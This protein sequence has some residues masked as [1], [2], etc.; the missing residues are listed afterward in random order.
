[1]HTLA[2]LAEAVGA[3][4]VGDGATEIRGVQPFELAGPGDI[5]L[6]GDRGY[7]AKLG[8]CRAAAAIV[9][10]RVNAEMP[11]LVVRN[12]KL[13]FARVLNLVLERPY[14]PTG[15]SEQAWI[16]PECGIDESASIHGFAS[17]GART[18][19]GARAIVHSA[20]VVGEGCRIGADSVLHP[21]VVLYPGVTLGERVVLHGGTVIGADGF[22][23]V[24]DGQQQVKLPQTGTVEIQDDV[25]IGANSCVDRATF[26]KTVIEKGVKLDNHVHV[27]HNCRIGQNTVIVGCVGISGSVDVGRNCVFAGQSGVGDHVR[28]GDNVVVMAKS[29]VTRDVPADSVVSGQ[30]AH[31]HRE[32]LRN[33]A[34]IRRLPELFA[35]LR[36]TRARLADLETRLRDA[37]V[38]GS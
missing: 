11:L 4:V 6:A 9:S 1:M 26:G 33:T 28:I 35:E 20:A 19:I 21:H 34:L 25:E 7:L 8:D 29:S 15:V 30:P 14:V 16:G 13:A 32:E 37:H 38:D 23:Y 12:P 10:E 22:G 27:G 17:I 2:R 3:E 36:E 31:S 24:F 18:V 5:T